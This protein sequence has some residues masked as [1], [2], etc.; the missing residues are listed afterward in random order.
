MKAT[1]A[2]VQMNLSDSKEENVERGADMIREAG[3]NG[4]QIICLPELANTQYFCYGMNREFMQLAERIPGPSSKAIGAA[5]AEADAWVVLPLYEEG[6]DGQ[7]YNSAVVIDRSGE[8]VGLYRKNV[9]PLMSFEGVEGVEKYYF[10]PGNL[11]YPVF[12]TDLGITIGITI[13]YERHF[14][15]GPRSLALAGADVIFVPTATPAGQQMWE[16]E[17]RAMAIAN[18]LWVGAVNRVGH[19]RG[20][21]VSDMSFYGGSLFAGPTGL[22]AQQAQTDGDEIVYAE[23]DTDASNKLREEWG[24]FRDRRPDIYTAITA[25]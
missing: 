4:A 21:A 9:I 14:P 1:C 6:E 15:E 12:E 17:L 19:D 10:R 23:I 20:D 25:P 7:L 22:V 3:R 2:L 18:L 16:V 11:G 5:A 24:F 8:P 13:C